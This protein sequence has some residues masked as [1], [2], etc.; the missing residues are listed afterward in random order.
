MHNLNDLDKLTELLFRALHKHKQGKLCGTGDLYKSL[1]GSLGESKVVELTEGESVNGKFDVLGKVRFPG[2]IEVK[3]ANKPTSGMLGA[4]SLL[5]KHN[6]CDWIALVD[7]SSIED[8]DY[9][10]SMIPHDA[11]FEHLL[12][13]N[14]KGNTPDYFR[15]SETYNES[16][17]L[18]VAATNLFL[19]YEVSIDIIKNL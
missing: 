11:F 13:P 8:S 17:N 6:A 1:V 16:D 15:W 7:A 2:R 14:K 9:R 4:W 3:T 19:K 5:C 18:S 10:I 12:T